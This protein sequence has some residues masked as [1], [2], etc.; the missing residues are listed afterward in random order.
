MLRF[1]CDSS[2][3]VL[4]RKN[5]DTLWVSY[6]GAGK[7]GTEG[8]RVLCQIQL[9]TDVDAT[10]RLRSFLNSASSD[11][12]IVTSHIFSYGLIDPR[13][14]AGVRCSEELCT[15][16]DEDQYCVISTRCMPLSGSESV[17]PEWSCQKE[18]AGSFFHLRI[19]IGRCVCFR[20][21]LV[22]LWGLTNWMALRKKFSK[23]G[24]GVFF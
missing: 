4:K 19:S 22:V 24:L 18:D 15:E 9:D 3:S 21:V 16:R 7:M 17:L 1:Y 23:C 13:D 12:E 20:A 10:D 11:E 14:G 6:S 2:C 5:L 8:I